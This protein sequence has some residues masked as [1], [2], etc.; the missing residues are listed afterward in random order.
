MT[1]VT[2]S[3]TISQPIAIRPCEV[4]SS[5]RSVIARSRTTVLATDSDRAEHQA[6]ADPPAEGDAEHQAEEG[7]DDD[8][9]ERAG[10]RD[11]PDGGQVPE[12]EVDPD[13]EHQQ[14]D[15]DVGELERE[16]AHRR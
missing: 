5:P 6:P 10:D 9:D 2:R 13:P 1:I 16:I 15:P 12:R 14:D 4:S 11:R 7:R 8:L 3:S